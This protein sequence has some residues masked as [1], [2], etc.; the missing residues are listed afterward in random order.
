MAKG[1]PPRPPET[2]RPLRARAF[3]LSFSHYTTR[4]ARASLILLA[5]S[6]AAIVSLRCR[7]PSPPAAARIRRFCPGSRRALGSFSVAFMASLE[8]SGPEV[9][10]ID[11]LA[12]RD[13]VSSGHR[14]LDV[15]TE[16]EFKERHPEAEDVLNI[17]YLFVT[18]EGR[19]NNPQFM[20]QVS[21][22]YG[23]EDRIVVEDLLV[24]SSLALAQRE[25]ELTG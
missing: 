6:G 18:P 21:S 15:R 13:L 16:E 25:R 4:A 1:L 9:V 20:E 14:F 24:R 3:S 5:S 10:T 2:P 19:V 8:S 22:A 11:V 17:P 23:L 12:A 7:P